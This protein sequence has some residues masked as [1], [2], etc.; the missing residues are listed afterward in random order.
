[1]I[2]GEGLRLRKCVWACLRLRDVC[3]CVRVTVCA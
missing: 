3:V 2:V 1:M